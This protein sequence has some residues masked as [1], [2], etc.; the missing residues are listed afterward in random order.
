MIKDKNT[1]TFYDIRAH[2]TATVLEQS[3]LTKITGEIKDKPWEDWWEKKHK[4]N[5]LLLTAAEKGELLIV[6]DI[7]NR[8]RHGDLAAEINAKTLDGFTALHFAASEGHLEMTMRLIKMGASVDAVT[9]FMR[10]PL[11]VACIRGYTEII[12]ILIQAK[13]NLNAQDK[14]G[15]TPIH[16]LAEKGWVEP[17]VICLNYKPDITIRNIYEETPIE[18]AANIKIRTSFSNATKF[19]TEESKAKKH[20]TYKR[21]VV[22]DLIL[23]NNRADMVKSLLFKKQQIGDNDSYKAE[24]SPEHSSIREGKEKAISRRS[25]RIRILEAAKELST[26]KLEDLK[27]SEVKSSSNKEVEDKIGLDQ[28]DIITM[29]GKGS[30]GEVYLVK[31]KPTD[32]YYAMKTLSKRRFMAHNLLKYAK[33]ERNVLC[34]TKNPFIVGL[35]FAFQ[36]AEKLF[37]ILEYCPGYTFV[38]VIGEILVSY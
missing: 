7:L 20:N 27:E 3:G 11:H 23:H 9:L 1:G 8:S 38:N 22:N 13:S 15:N 28:F 16:I 21:T 35:D 10:T 17:L 12:L 4:S 19:F 2:D 33:A 26:I 5:N 37:L 24:L 30:F 14:D 29:L 6:L 31:Y 32:K 25:R 34:Y 36:T 18:I